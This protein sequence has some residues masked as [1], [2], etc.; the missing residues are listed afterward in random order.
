MTDAPE[1]LI[2]PTRSL[3]AGG[4]ALVGALA[5]VAIT[6]VL[7]QDAEG[8]GA[9]VL[10]SAW[11]MAFLL[12]ARSLLAARHGLFLDGTRSALGLCLTSPRDVAWLPLTSLAEA[13]AQAII[14]P[15]AHE[16]SGW[17]G[18]LSLVGGVD[19]VLLESGSRDFVEGL[20][21]ALRER[22][23]LTGTREDPLWRPGEATFAVRIGAPL[24]PVVGAFGFALTLTGSVALT[25]GFSGGEPV[26]GFMLGPLLAL[27]GLALLAVV[28]AKRL[29]R[30]VLSF[31]GQRWRHAFMLGRRVLSERSVL[32][33][34]PTFRL[35][36]LGARGAMLELIGDDGTLVIGAGTTARSDASVAA[37]L[38]L[39]GHF[40]EPA[41]DET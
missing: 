3:A 27:A 10:G 41:H 32:G 12:A 39:P 19:V 30:E 1:V 24:Q 38:A 4:A 25:R 28:L 13:R 40:T 2:P 7:L 23:D 29:G 11:V 36:L 20:T 16:I 35:Q 14:A 33:P 26:S 5:A 9:L 34:R 8:P 37:L 15:D 22:L 17:R 21:G 31:D 18:V 6:V